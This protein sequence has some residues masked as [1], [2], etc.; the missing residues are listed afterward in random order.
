MAQHLP[1]A[2]VEV[3][4]GMAE[5]VIVEQEPL[6]LLDRE[7][8][9]EVVQHQLTVVV[10]VVLMLLETMELAQQVETAETVLLRQ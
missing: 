3:A 5:V 7:M 1:E 4:E 10:V 9:V 2:L 8:L 6:E